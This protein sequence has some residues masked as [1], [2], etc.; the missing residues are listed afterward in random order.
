MFDK[1]N[2]KEEVSLFGFTKTVREFFWNGI[3]LLILGSFYRALSAVSKLP[4]KLSDMSDE[5]INAM[6]IEMTFSEK[7]IAM[8]MLLFSYWMLSKAFLG[9]IDNKIKKHGLFRV[10]IYSLLLVLCMILVILFL[11]ILVILLIAY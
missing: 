10:L 3:A 7:A 2:W 5:E 8:V 11:Q 6:N 1:I 9:D 4:A